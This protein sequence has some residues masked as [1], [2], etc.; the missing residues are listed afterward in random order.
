[1][2]AKPVRILAIIGSGETSPTMVTLHKELVARLSGKPVAVLLETPYGFQENVDQVSAKVRRYFA[3]SVGVR[4]EVAAGLRAPADAT[5]ADLDRGIAML[6]RAGWV[7]AGPGSPSYA[8]TQ[9]RASQVGA[10]LRDRLHRDG[11]TVF[12]SAAACTLGRFA[13]PVYEIYKVGMRP[14]WHDGL[15]LLSDLGLAAAII[16]HY[17]NAEGGN[18]D[19]RYCY[20]GERRLRSL[21]AQLPP[22]AAILGVDEHTAAVFD[23]HAETL[24]VHGRGGVTVRRGGASDVLASGLAVPLSELRDRVAVAGAPTECPEAAGR[25]EPEPGEGEA[26]PAEATSLMTMV[27]ACELRFDEAERARNAQAMAGAVLDLEE[28][29]A[30]WSTDT[31]EAANIEHARAG[32]RSLVVHLG[33]AAAQGLRDPREQLAAIVGPVLALRAE[34]RRRGDYALGDALRDALRSGGIQIQDTREGTRWFAAAA[35]RSSQTDR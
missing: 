21:E 8:A 19:T 13:L 32:L 7:F 31:L 35:S 25:R 20:V 26:P 28:A 18:H 34:L 27:H 24:T 16:P 15:D 6:R 1:M 2:G 30:S 5:G 12:S 3:V 14:A 10:A 22:G 4:V 23:L 29:I 11:I 9:W 17:D 33:D